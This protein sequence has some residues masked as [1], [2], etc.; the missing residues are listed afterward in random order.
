M[1]VADRGLASGIFPM[2]QQ[3]RAD[4][5]VTFQNPNEFRATIPAVTDDA[6]ELHE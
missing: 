1:P 4:A 6:D 5:G 3:D 2:F